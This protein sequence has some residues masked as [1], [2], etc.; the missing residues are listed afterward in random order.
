[1]PA[2]RGFDYMESYYVDVQVQPAQNV[3]A[4][5][6]VNILGHVAVNPIDEIFYENRGRQ[7]TAVIDNEPIRL[8][9]LERLRV[10]QAS[11]SWDDRWFSL[12]G[13]YRT[14][15]L[16]WGFEGDFFGL[17]HDAYYGE[18]IDIYNGMAPV[19]FEVAA[20][21]SLRGLKLAYGPQLWWGANPAVFLKYQREVGKT[22]FTGVVHEDIAA[23][24]TATTSSAPNVEQTRK[25][26]LQAYTERGDWTIE[27]GVLWAGNEKVG[28]GF[29]IYDDSN[30]DDITIKKDVISAE[31]SWGFKGKVTV[32]KGPWRW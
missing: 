8:E 12:E 23:G 30:P 1:M 25:A 16:H 18:N 4:D 2:Y 6:S 10:Y 17:Y 21:K 20:K 11:V 24:K 28:R 27:G 19:G 14:G 3:V 7:R 32:Q 15:H 26:S 31:D 22:T 29:N 13:F 5:L 9:G